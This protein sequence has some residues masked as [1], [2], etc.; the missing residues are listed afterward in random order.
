MQAE[1]E[2]LKQMIID[3]IFDVS[4]VKYK[5]TLVR[6]IDVEII[7]R[8]LSLMDNKQN[9]CTVLDY[10]Q[11]NCINEAMYYSGI[12]DTATLKDSLNPHRIPNPYIDYYVYE[13]RNKRKCNHVQKLDSLMEKTD[14]VLN[15][16]RYNQFFHGILHIGEKGSGKTMTQNVWLYNYHEELENNN[17]F[18]IRLDA[19]KLEKIWIRSETLN[20]ELRYSVEDYLLGQMLYVFVKHFQPLFKNRYSPLCGRIADKLANSPLNTLPE[21]IT[22]SKKSSSDHS[23]REMFLTWAKNKSFA[24]LIDCFEY[25]E[26]ITAIYENTYE[27]NGSKRKDDWVKLDSSKSFFIDRILLDDMMTSELKNAWYEVARV[28]RKFILEEKFY[29]FYIID[30]IDSLDFYVLDRKNT[31]K[32]MLNSLLRFPLCRSGA[33]NNCYE[34]RLISL[35]DTTFANLRKL[36]NEISYA[37]DPSVYDINNFYKIEQE[38]NNIFGD[39]LDRRLSFAQNRF[40]GSQSNKPFISKVLHCIC[41]TNTIPDEKRWHSNYRCFLNNHITLAKLITFKYYFAGAPDNFNIE[42]Q[43][44]IFEEDNFF[45]N[46]EAYYNKVH[47]R[48]NLGDHCFNI[49]NNESSVLDF[50]S[51][52]VDTRILL[53]IKSGKRVMHE[54]IVKYLSAYNYSEHTI[55]QKIEKMVSAGMIKPD[56]TDNDKIIYEISDKGHFILELFYNR[57]TYLY[58]SC[59]DSNIPEQLVELLTI[60][61]NNT[62]YMKSGERFFPA[63]CLITGAYF[64]RYLLFANAQENRGKKKI[65]RELG[66][67]NPR[68]IQELPINKDLLGKSILDMLKVASKKSDCIKKI[69]DWINTECNYAYE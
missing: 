69:K 42:E 38:T 51:H 35:R 21:P 61:P 30:G 24:T 57:I 6:P 68:C 16:I 41:S 52:F 3:F 8:K 54:S 4:K 5:G 37:G 56:F 1:L 65:L 34:I 63:A 62:D 27:E 9:V 18:W 66:I 44:K 64:L 23:S 11:R 13:D 53:L 50:D 33:E 58:Y 2:Q 60:A 15:L 7:K 47:T 55:D 19:A 49:F 48:T 10:L 39:I 26:R 29:L 22:N 43:I 67:S 28:L 40:I 36:Y 31:I 32:K 25:F 46:G 59:L 14:G 20:P 17:I 45:L 12:F